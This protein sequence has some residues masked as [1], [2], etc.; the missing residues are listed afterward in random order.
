M[1]RFLIALACLFALPWSA[2]AQTATYQSSSVAAVA[3]TSQTALVVTAPTAIAVGD[4]LVGTGGTL[5]T[6]SITPPTGWTTVSNDTNGTERVYVFTRVADAGDAAAANFTFTVGTFGQAAVA[7]YRISTASSTLP[8]PVFGT[9]PNATTQTLPN[10]TTAANNSLVIW[11]VYRSIAAAGPGTIDHGIERVD[12]VGSDSW[13][14]GATEA[15]ATAGVQSG[16]TVTSNSFGTKRLMSIA[17]SPAGA[18]GG[19]GG[20]RKLTLT[21]VG[22]NQ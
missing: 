13:I 22:D 18:G 6:K 14:Y 21:G 3:T 12:N 8:T 1:K 11:A 7:L 9:G 19:G 20:A 10:I 4:L 15:F 2:S 17:V 16:A 5:D